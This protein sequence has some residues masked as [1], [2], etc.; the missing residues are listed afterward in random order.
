MSTVVRA[1]LRSRGAYE[2]FWAGEEGEGPG[3]LDDLNELS[4]AFANRELRILMNNGPVG[5]SLYKLGGP[6]FCTSP[7]TTDHLPAPRPLLIT[8]TPRRI[9]SGKGSP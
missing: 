9:F 6:G 1:S 3:L 7:G 2:R 4:R 8:V 5:C